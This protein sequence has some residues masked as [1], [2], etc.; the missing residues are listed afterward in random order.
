MKASA[1][2]RS[3]VL[4]ERYALRGWK[5][6]PCG[7][8]DQ[9]TLR[10]QFFNREQY[11]VLLR[12]DGMSDMHVEELTE[13]QTEL[14]E[15]LVKDEVLTEL[16][17]DD[18]ARL[19]PFQEYV[20]FPSRYIMQ[21]H[22]SITGRCN[23]RCKHCMVSS[24]HT[25]LGEPSLEQC[26]RVIDQLSA[27]GIY[28]ME[29]TGGEPLV[30]PHFWDIVDYGLNHNVILSGIYTNAPLVNLELVD[31]LTCR[32][33]HPVFHISFDGVG[34]HDWLR[35]VAGAEESANRAFALCREAGFPTTAALT[36]HGEN[37]A[38]L[39]DTVLHLASLGVEL[40]KVAGMTDLGEWAKQDPRYKLSDEDYFEEILRYI[41]QYVEDEAPTAIQIWSAFLCDGV[42]ATSVRGPLQWTKRGMSEQRA[43]KMPA[44]DATRSSVYISPEGVVLPCMTMA[45]TELEQSFPNLF[46]EDLRDI[47]QDSLHFRAVD[48]RASDLREAHAQ[49]RG[50]EGFFDCLCGCR[51]EAFV[52][53]G[54]LRG[55]GSTTCQFYRSGY[56]ARVQEAIDEAF[57]NAGGTKGVMSCLDGPIICR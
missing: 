1:S 14:L 41:P 45:G 21:A 25:A 40:I 4:A 32:G 30:H 38:C 51:A 19:A 37:R 33:L 56:A 11:E 49:C 35:G 43:L 31:G 26:Q 3:Y 20:A 22:W 15:E 29:L 13:S 46:E 2:G 9:R 57:G 47:L 28:S 23:Y 10:A 52:E 36:L 16:A 34:H 39:R 53:N 48:L 24:P 27:C 7:L 54:D 55:I 6:L 18:R 17:P 42:G 5:L 12:A 50:C 8:L 44:C